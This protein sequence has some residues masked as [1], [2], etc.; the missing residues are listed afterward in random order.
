MLEAAKGTDPEMRLAAASALTW[1]PVD[2][3]RVLPIIMPLLVE[4]LDNA[5]DEERPVNALG[6]IGP[7]ARDAIPKL[8]KLAA[9]DQD[10]YFRTNVVTALRKIEG[11]SD[12]VISTLIDL[13]RCECCSAICSK[14]PGRDWS[15]C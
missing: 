5:R 3:K 10:A 13:L 2:K 1:V 12:F 15:V 6:R 14:N 7:D 4:G 8:H 11:D 9:A